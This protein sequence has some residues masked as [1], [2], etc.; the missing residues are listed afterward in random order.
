VGPVALRAVGRGIR[1]C[2][3][4]RR[5]AP[6]P[7]AAAPP[8]DGQWTL[9]AKNYP[10]TR[11]SELSEIDAQTVRQLRV[12]FTFSTDVVRGHEAARLVVD[13]TMYIVSSYPNRLY[14]LDLTKPGVP[15]QWT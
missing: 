9:P 5:S 14:V 13:D 12:E 8:D 7:S 6:T 1:R 10:S 11:F 2:V 3:G 4:T 15:L